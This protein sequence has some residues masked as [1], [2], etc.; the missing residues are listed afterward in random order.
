MYLRFRLPSRSNP[1]I[2]H[3]LL[4][5]S[6]IASPNGLQTHLNVS[7]HSEA[8]QTEKPSRTELLDVFQYIRELAVAVCNICRV[9]VCFNDV[10]RYLYPD[11]EAVTSRTGVL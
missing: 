11:V 8:L 1:S 4:L 3:S 7:T 9:T 10:N 6:N 5:P 2:G